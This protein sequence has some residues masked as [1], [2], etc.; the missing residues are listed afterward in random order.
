MEKGVNSDCNR[1]EYLGYKLGSK[2]SQCIRLT[3]FSNATVKTSNFAYYAYFYEFGLQGSKMYTAPC[4][5]K[6]ISEDQAASIF[7]VK[8]SL[9]MRKPKTHKR[10]NLQLCSLN[11]DIDLQD[12]MVSQH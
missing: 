2:G 9:Q 3:I 11:V 1:N 4:M 6:D 7:H 8:I 12:D 5:D 10:Q